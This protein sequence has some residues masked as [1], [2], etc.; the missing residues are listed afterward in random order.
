MDFLK[1]IYNNEPDDAWVAVLYGEPMGGEFPKERSMV[2]VGDLQELPP[3]QLHVYVVPHTYQDKGLAVPSEMCGTLWMESDD[4]DFNY[5]AITEVAPTLVVETSPGR[6]HMYWVLDRLYPMQVILDHNR[7]LAQKYLKYDRSGWDTAQ[8]MR[9]PGFYNHKYG[10]PFMVRIIATGSSGIPLYDCFGKLNLTVALEGSYGARDQW[11]LDEVYNLTKGEV[12][13][14]HAKRLPKMYIQHLEKRDPN[15]QAAMWYLYRQSHALALTPGEAFALIKDSPNNKFSGAY[16]NGDRE[17]W[18]E[19]HSAYRMMEE[20]ES[21]H[22]RQAIAGARL[23]GNLNREQRNQEIAS[24]VLDDML[25]R[26][27]FYYVPRDREVYYQTTSYRGDQRM[28][29]ASKKNV[30]FAAYIDQ[31][32]GL[33]PTTNEFSYTLENLVNTT[34]EKGKRVVLRTTTYFDAENR[35]LYIADQKG[36]MYRL[37]GE[38]VSHHENGVDG[39]MFRFNPDTNRSITP[40]PRAGGESESLFEQWIADW[41]NYSTEEL[42]RRES[43]T[44]VRAWFYSLFLLEESRGMLVIEGPPGAGKTTVFKAMEWLFNGRE[45]NVAQMPDDAKELRE[46]LRKQ[47]HVFYD[48]VEAM[49]DAQQTIISTC[50]TGAIDPHRKLWTDDDMILSEM[51]AGIGLSTMDASYLRSDIADRSILL[52]VG[53]FAAFQDIDTIK[54]RVMEH[55][56]AIWGEVMDDLNQLIAMMHRDEGEVYQSSLRMSNVQ[57]IVQMVAR[58]YNVNGQRLEKFIQRDQADRNLSDKPIWDALKVWLAKP[59]SLGTPITASKLHAE[60]SAIAAK[61]DFNYKR[62]AKSPRQLTWKL[63]AMEHEIMDY[64]IEWESGTRGFG[65]KFTKREEGNAD[66]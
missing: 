37:D 32:Y 44:L 29:T 28:M 40:T 64:S 57:R 15:Q 14:A 53:R 6:F 27:E 24:L 58:L 61:E 42:S 33:N 19:I 13:G 26:G 52:K 16:Y 46:S 60:L 55:R 63:K 17:L 10:Y 36:G 65:I 49:R 48:G 8:P 18:S 4:D 45:A 22:C 20:S 23:N 43:M 25:L 35:L 54:A 50:V 51:K 9:V 38:S 47:H 21:G 7:A 5:R 12:L 31:Q 11:H 1:T 59:G 3:S 39:V 56:D 41:P 2:R 66:L 34:I 62:D 30:E